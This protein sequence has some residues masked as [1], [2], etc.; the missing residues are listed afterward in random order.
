[1]QKYPARAR[2]EPSGAHEAGISSSSS[3]QTPKE[4]PLGAAELPPRGPGLR[5][6]AVA[7]QDAS[8]MREPAISPCRGRTALERHLAGLAAAGRR[9]A[10][11]D[12]L[13]HGSGRRESRRTTSNGGTL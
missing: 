1:M 9:T 11:L 13:P 5:A 6:Q 7:R 8:A 12:V 2:L 10:A 4:R 3:R